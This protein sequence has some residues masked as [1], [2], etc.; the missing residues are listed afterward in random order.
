MCHKGKNL[1]MSKKERCY[2]QERPG[3][4]LKSLV[5]EYNY[6]K[7]HHVVAIMHYFAIHS[8]VVCGANSIFV[9]DTWCETIPK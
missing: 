8:S 4:E 2:Y 9:H 6:F 3:M 5:S 1:Q 7:I